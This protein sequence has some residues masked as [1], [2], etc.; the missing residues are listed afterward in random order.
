MV[1]LGSLPGRVSMESQEVKLGGEISHQGSLL[2][3]ILES[4]R[5]KQG[6]LTRLRE[7]IGFALGEISLGDAL[8][9]ESRL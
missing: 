9:S 1:E 5:E 7:R 6:G 2:R 4:W 3:S 8:G